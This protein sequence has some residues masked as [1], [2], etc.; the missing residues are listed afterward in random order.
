MKSQARDAMVEWLN[1]GP[2]NPSS[3]HFEGQRAK[4]K[5]DESREIIAEQLGCLFGEV[6]FTSSGTEAAN[7][8]IL[9]L[10]NSSTSGNRKKIIMSAVEHHCA[11][12]T[13]DRL[14][15]MGY[16]L[17]IAPV[18]RAGKI[19]L[20]QF[21]TSLDESVLLVCIMHCNNELGTY[22]PMKEI[23]DL[24]HHVGAFVF[25]DAVQSFQIPDEFGLPWDIKTLP[26]DMVS[27]SGHKIGG[28]AGTGALYVRS[29]LKIDP[30]I[31][32]GGQER[33]MR[34]GTE[35][36]AN[37][38]GFSTAAKFLADNSKRLVCRNAFVKQLTSLSP[39]VLRSIPTHPGIAHFMCP[40]PIAESALIALD[41][42]GISAASGAACASGSIE[43]SHVLL[44]CGFSKSEAN[45]GLRFSLGDAFSDQ[46][47]RSAATIVNQV[48]FELADLHR[49]SHREQEASTNWPK[50]PVTPHV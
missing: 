30:L 11:L 38:I 2:G 39:T 48:I 43:P 40:Y 4:R 24:A 6:L 26:A 17:L 7:H 18:N 46:E 35:A 22:Q 3:L 13:R 10:A 12:A 44:A 1:I 34:G 28:P 32:G 37:I 45:S 49:N 29:G 23:I 9:G 20:E 21:K 8:A 27:I 15:Q 19:E 31:Y 14:L 50:I 33:E 16:E 36:I 47:I 41:Q 42:R 25:M 5:I